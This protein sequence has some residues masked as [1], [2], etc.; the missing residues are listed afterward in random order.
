MRTPGRTLTLLALLLIGPASAARAH[1]F[2][3]SPSIYS[4]APCRPI[5]VG[6]FAGTGFRGEGKPW[7]PD[8]AVRFL[9]RAGRVLDLAPAAA[10][11]DFAWAR[12]APSDA[13]GAMLAF[14]STFTPIELPAAAFDRYLEEEGL[15]AARRARAGMPAGIPGRERYRRCAKAWLGGADDRRANTPLGLPLEIVP[16]AA[17]GAAARLLVRVLRGGRPLAG[18]LVQAWRAP[19]GPGAVPRDASERDSAGV[20]WKGRTDGRGLVVVPVAEAGEWLVS[21]VDMVPSSNRVE[22]DWESTWASLTFAR[23]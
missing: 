6:A 15:M 21:A 16:G 17:P 7:S 13:G 1:Q 2:W 10:P 19:L 14:E 20:V 18:A 3:L 4:G 23:R 22:A 9:V 12:F 8:H 11:G 5:A